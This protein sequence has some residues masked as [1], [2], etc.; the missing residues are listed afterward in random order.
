MKKAVITGLIAV[1]VFSMVNCATII[2]GDDQEIT[3]TSHPDGAR[4]RIYD[5]NTNLPVWDSTAPSIVTLKKGSGYFEPASYRVEV[6]KQGY[7]TQAFYING[8]I[9]IGWYLVGNLF[10][11]NLLGW[12][13]IDPITG[14]M[15]T[16][17]P[18]NIYAPLGQQ[19]A[20]PG[21]EGELLVVLKQDMPTDLYESL[22]LV[23][24]N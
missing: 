20:A 12:L 15:W 2:S 23:R 6:S 5:N 24:L 8:N 14:A 17:A 3:I 16:L 13:I 4:I 10:L 21:G 19:S 1:L 9:D 22:D 7:Q 11:G 18:D